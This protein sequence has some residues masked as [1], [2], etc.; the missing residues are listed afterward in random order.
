MIRKKIQTGLDY[1]KGKNTKNIHKSGP[2]RSRKVKK[3][4]FEGP[5]RFL[6]GPKKVKK[7]LKSLKIT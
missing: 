1:K 7:N 2:K 3:K 4:S 6:G 5:K